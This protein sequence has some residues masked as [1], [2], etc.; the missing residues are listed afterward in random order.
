MGGKCFGL[1]IA[2]GALASTLA[3]GAPNDLLQQG[4]ALHD[5]HC[6]RCHDTAIYTRKD[7]KIRPLLRLVWAEGLSWDC[8]CYSSVFLRNPVA[9]PVE[10]WARGPRV[11]STGGPRWH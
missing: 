11:W 9:G 3:A 6:L 10:L 4:K 2:T 1:S 5:A 7:R 8:S